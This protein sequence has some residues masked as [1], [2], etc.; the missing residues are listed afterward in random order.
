MTRKK[1]SYEASIQKR[2]V[3][4]N[5]Q[6]D[7]REREGRRERD[8]QTE[9]ETHRERERQRQRESIIL[10]ACEKEKAVKNKENVFVNC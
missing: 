9:I 2:K 5:L 7:E 8:R 3:S 4:S 10:T 1:Y 6:N